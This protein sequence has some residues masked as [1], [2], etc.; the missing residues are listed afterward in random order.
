MNP[1]DLL[2]RYPANA[3]L[4]DGSTITIRPLA[5][6]DKVELMRFFTRV[7]EEDRFYLHDNVTA[8]E[9]IRSMAEQM[10]ELGVLGVFN[11][12]RLEAA[13]EADGVGEDLINNAPSQEEITRAFATVQQ[14]KR[15]GY[16]ILNSFTQMGMM[17]TNSPL[18]YR[19][20]WP[21]FLLPIEANG[22]V[23]DCMSWGSNPVDN[24][25][26]TPLADVLDHPRLR[27]LAG[28]KGEACCKCVS[29]H[30]VEIS[31][32]CEGSMEPLLAWV[33]GLWQ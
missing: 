2:L 14:L 4:S 11:A 19:C 18:S 13:S 20:H 16:P 9:T 25:R 7:P 22:D 8:P 3:T 33:Y 12:M 15:E 17:Q 29:L 30:R 32:V 31:E 21:K 24:I 6:D 23:V 26:R 28:E 27:A 1:T 10:K 5:S